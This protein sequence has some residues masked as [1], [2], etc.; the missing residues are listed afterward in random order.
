MVDWI[1]S[2]ASKYLKEKMDSPFVKFLKV[3]IL[4]QL[5]QKQSY[6]D[7]L[8][9]VMKQDSIVNSYGVQEF[10]LPRL[11]LNLYAKNSTSSKT[12]KSET[13]KIRMISANDKMH[14]FVKA[15]GLF[16]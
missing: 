3:D 5:A 7:E 6:V 4:F 2:G 13:A 16:K 12:K 11:H 10:H 14:D 1:C 9:K 8:K 15:K